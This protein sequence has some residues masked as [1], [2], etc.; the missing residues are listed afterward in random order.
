MSGWKS[1]EFPAGRTTLE[2]EE[3]APLLDTTRPAGGY[4][5]PSDDQEVLPSRQ[6][7]PTPNLLPRKRSGR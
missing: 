4:G 3:K 5:T 6:A 2:N 7:V 1:K